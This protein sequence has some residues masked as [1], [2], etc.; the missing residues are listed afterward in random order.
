MATTLA[1]VSPFSVAVDSS[2]NVYVAEFGTNRI[3]KIDATGKITTAIGDGIQGFAG[4]GGPAEQSGDEPADRRGG[5]FL[6][7]RLFRRFAQ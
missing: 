1:M 7:Q 2:G 4:D 6:G 5:G 3:R